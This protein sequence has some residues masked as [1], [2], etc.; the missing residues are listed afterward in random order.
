H[1]LPETLRDLAQQA[2][3]RGVAERVV[4]RFEAV[5]I[6][7][8]DRER[9]L[10]TPRRGEQHLEALVEE[11]PVRQLREA[12]EVREAADLLFDA[13]ALADVLRGSG[14]SRRPPASARELHLEVDVADRAVGGNDADVEL[15]VSETGE[16]RFPR[17]EQVVAIIGM[18][19]TQKEVDLRL[20]A[21]RLDAEHPVHLLRPADVATL[22]VFLPV[23]EACDL[24]RVL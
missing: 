21:L 12:V 24:L 4:D 1:A 13:L 19:E 22:D 11:G 7:E 18:N 16:D 10:L 23:P 17:S 3:A 2:V 20:E 9:M 6:H 14:Q 8:E 15:A 5:Q